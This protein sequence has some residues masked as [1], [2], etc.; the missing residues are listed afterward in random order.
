G[1]T[2]GAAIS[3]PHRL[4]KARRCAATDDGGSTKADERP[5]RKEIK[6]AGGSRNAAAERATTCRSNPH[7][8]LQKK[9][10]ILRCPL[11]QTTKRYLLSAGGT[12]GRGRVS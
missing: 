12:G 11:T 3:T 9:A 10:G 5:A 6:E 1:Q 8:G 2:G 4:Q 7:I